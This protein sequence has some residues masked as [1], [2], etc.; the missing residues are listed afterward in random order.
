M[1]GTGVTKERKINADPAVESSEG[2]KHQP[3]YHTSTCK[4]VTLLSG[5]KQS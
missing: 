2:V 3:N 5:I 1:M 4:T